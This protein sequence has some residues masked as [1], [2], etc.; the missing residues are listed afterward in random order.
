VNFRR[1]DTVFSIEDGG[2]DGKDDEGVEDCGAGFAGGFDADTSPRRVVIGFPCDDGLR[3]M[4]YPSHSLFNN[5]QKQIQ[6]QILSW[7][8]GANPIDQDCSF[9]FYLQVS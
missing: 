8:E 4:A 6:N 2:E 7:V 3:A 1:R 9:Y 5:L